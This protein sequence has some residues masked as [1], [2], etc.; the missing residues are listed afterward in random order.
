MALTNI[1]WK[2]NKQ[3]LRQELQS[4][5]TARVGTS[6][7][8]KVQDLIRNALKQHQIY[9]SLLDGAL[10]EAF[11]LH[12]APQSVDAVVEKIVSDVNIQVIEKGTALATIRIEAVKSDYQE[13]LD[14]QDSMVQTYKGQLLPWLKWLI[15]SETAV[16]AN[17][18][19]VRGY[20]PNPPSRTN[21]ALMKK[22]GNWSLSQDVTQ[23]SYEPQDNWI[24]QS[25]NTI[26][27][28]LLKLFKS[29]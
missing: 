20:F 28:E 13:I 2:I 27:P 15:G 23:Y 16:I 26:G 24:T 3:Q 11:G 4:Q 17:Y 29:I 5:L 19:I 12:T 10:Y 18:H 8:S 21:K 9:T 25:I 1:K 14:I 7:K 22:D 6:V